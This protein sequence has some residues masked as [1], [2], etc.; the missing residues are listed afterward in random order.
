VPVKFKKDQA[1][2]S[3]SLTPLID[4]VFQLLLFFIVATR[5]ADEDREMIVP[6]PDA[7]EAKPITYVPQ[8]LFINI[9]H[10]GQYFVGGKTVDEIELEDI[11]RR[12]AVNNPANQSVR[13]HADRRVKFQAVVTAVNLCKRTGIQDYTTDIAADPS[14]Q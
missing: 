10:D 2:L 6:L 5:F 9:N 4:V 13:I 11:L 7:S 1:L 3:L 14:Q 12:A 8:E